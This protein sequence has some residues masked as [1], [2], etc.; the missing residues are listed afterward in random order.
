MCGWQWQ[1]RVVSLVLN[2]SNAADSM[3]SG[4]GRQ[5]FEA[6]IAVPLRATGTYGYDDA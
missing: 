3:F 2:Y 6:M 4:L 1:L 5:L